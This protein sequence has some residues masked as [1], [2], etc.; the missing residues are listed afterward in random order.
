MTTTGNAIKRI[1]VTESTW[2]ALHG[3][4]DPGQTYDELLAEM[5]KKHLA[6]ADD[7][8]GEVEY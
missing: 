3:L 5:I 6:D 4:R 1:P 8:D 2:A 7:I